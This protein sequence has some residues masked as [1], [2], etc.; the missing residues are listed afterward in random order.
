MLALLEQTLRSVPMLSTLGIRPEVARTGSIVLRLPLSP[1][2]TDH[3]GALHPAAIFAVGELAAAIVLGTHLDL[4]DLVHR[5]KSTKIKYY[6]SS[7]EDV[8]AHAD[9]STEILERI[10]Q[11]IESGSV[12]ADLVV[13]V[14]DGH[15]RDVAELV[16]RF[17]FQPR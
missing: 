10:L 5:Q 14:L 8:T 17:T 11:G 6:R 15:G 3:A 9:V 2:I 12:H 13:R 1:G 7:T 4:A 16:S